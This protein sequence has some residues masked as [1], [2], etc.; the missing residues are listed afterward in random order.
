MLRTWRFV[1]KI[2]RLPQQG[3]MRS[4][5]DGSS[6]N[7]SWGSTSNSTHRDLPIEF[8]AV[9][10]WGANTNV[11]KTLVSAG[12]VAAAVRN[13]A[14]RLLQHQQQQEQQQQPSNSNSNNLPIAFNEA[15]QRAAATLINVPACNTQDVCTFIAQS[16]AHRELLRS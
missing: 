16:H 8:P 4:S 10:I 15:Y 9:C 11:G 6:S 13:K 14:S 3:V 1:T 2:W 5:S 7:R 12:L